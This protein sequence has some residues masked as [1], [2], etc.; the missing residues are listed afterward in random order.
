MV[1]DVVVE[2]QVETLGERRLQIRV[3]SGLVQRVGI[4]VDDEQL[5]ILYN[6]AT[7]TFFPSRYEGFGLPIL[8]SMACG[9]PVV[10]CQ[11]SSLPEVGGEAALYVDPD[12]IDAMCNYMA[13][14]EQG[15]LTKGDL[16]LQCLEQASKFSWKRCATQTIEAYQKCL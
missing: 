5:S 1:H 13:E 4:I 12:D 16:T 9:T 15:N 10:T 8:E 14:F 3:T 7:A 2:A 6:E 11:N